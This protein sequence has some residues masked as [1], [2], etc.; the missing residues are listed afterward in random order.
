[1]KNLLYILILILFPV[2]V[3]AQD[4][5][6]VKSTTYKQPIH[7]SISD[8]SIEQANV[9]VSYFDGLGRPIQQIA[10]KQS[11]TGKD[12]VTHI[13]YDAFGRQTKEFLPYLFNFSASFNA[14]CPPS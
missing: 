3:L 13:E 12:I 14:V 10:H 2:L 1:M 8:P 6:W 7:G 4:Q 11:N 5:N 9:Q